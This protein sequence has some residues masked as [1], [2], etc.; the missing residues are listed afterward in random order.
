MGSAAVGGGGGWVHD[1]RVRRIDGG[2]VVGSSGDGVGDG[3]CMGSG[4]IILVDETDGA[5]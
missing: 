5:R 3:D 1:W 2:Y 4:G